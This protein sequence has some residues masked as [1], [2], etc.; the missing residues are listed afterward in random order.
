MA[1][2]TAENIRHASDI[3]LNENVAEIPE[4]FARETIIDNMQKLLTEYLIHIG[5]LS[6][7]EMQK[8][9]VTNMFNTITDIERAADH[10]NNIAEQAQ[11]ADEHNISFSEIG[12]DDLRTISDKVIESFNSSIDAFERN[13][14]E[15]VVRTAHLEDQVDEMEEDMR[16][17]HILRLS[18]GQCVPQAGVVFLDVISDLERI[19]DHADNIADYV[20]AMI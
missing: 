12:Q 19:S 2:I 17:T 9:E 16:E 15:A 10:A 14:M 6:L 4:V 8:L 11:Y 18:S 7:N 1:R 13:D 20:K 5:N 3:L